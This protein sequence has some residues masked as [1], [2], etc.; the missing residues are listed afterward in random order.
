MGNICRSPSAEGFVRAGLERAGLADRVR[1]DSAGTHGYHL[2][3]PPDSRAIRMAAE[4]GVDISD[5][6]ARRVQTG[7]LREFDLVLAMDQ[8]NLRALE[9]MGQ[10]LAAGARRAELGLMLDYSPRFGHLREVP[11]PYYGE[12]GD[13]RYMCELL[14]DAT[15]GLL[16]SLSRRLSDDRETQAR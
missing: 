7:D 9:Q 12:L 1:A 13:F 14:E 10:G 16:D 15:I 3:H 5:L 11:D 8:A 4:F 2:G 6:R